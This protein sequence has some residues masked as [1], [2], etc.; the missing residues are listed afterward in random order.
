MAVPLTRNDAWILVAIGGHGEYSTLRNV[1]TSADYVN[2][3]VP[4]AE[5]LEQAI[6]HLGKTGLVNVTHEGYA[7]T[8]A[9]AKVLE[10]FGAGKK[11]VI[12]LMLDLMK[13]WE[14]T[15][16]DEVD[17]NF[18]YAVDATAYSAATEDYHLG[19]KPAE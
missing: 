19:S 12:T 1:I 7:V 2:R 17:P 8:S 5:E 15:A 16:I 4:T 3:L 6:N 14:G 11:G 10:D 13:A 9:G 18:L